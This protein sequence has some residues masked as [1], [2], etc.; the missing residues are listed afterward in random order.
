MPAFN[1]LLFAYGLAFGI[2]NKLPFLRGRSDFTDALIKCTY[3]LGFHTGWMSWLFYLGMER[4]SLGS[5]PWDIAFSVVWSV[6]TWGMSSAAFSYGVDTAIRWLEY[7][8]Q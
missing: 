4:P 8:P 5:G 3:C 7:R 2:Q 6:V 1:Y